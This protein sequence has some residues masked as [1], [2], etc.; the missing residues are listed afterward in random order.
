MKPLT[1]HRKL[2][3]VKGFTPPLPNW[4]ILLKIGEQWL[5]GIKG[6]GQHPGSAAILI[7][8]RWRLMNYIKAEGLLEKYD[9]FI[10]TRS[11]FVWET[12]H[13]PIEY[14]NPENIWVPDGESHGGLTDRHAVVSNKNL[15]CYLDLLK[16]IITNPHTLFS[17][18]VY[19][20]DWNLEQLIDFHLKKSG[21]RENVRF[22]PYVMYSARTLGGNTR[23]A[24]GEWSKDLG[25]Y[26]KYPA[27]F[28]AAGSYKRLIQSPSDWG[29]YFSNDGTLHLNMRIKSTHGDSFVLEHPYILKILLILLRTS[30]LPFHALRAQILKILQPLINKNISSLIT[31]NFSSLTPNRLELSIDY[32]NKFGFLYITNS[33]RGNCEKTLLD[34]VELLFDESG[35]INLISLKDQKFYNIDRAGRLTK[36]RETAHHF[37]FENKYE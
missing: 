34:K 4:R 24:Q 27:E 10:V 35:T 37:T 3:L 16:P 9:T 21:L 20:N 28:Q 19:R 7:Y 8:F 18:M 17:E 26:I 2:S 30:K 32:A 6:I 14:L 25:Y 5:G 29:R 11:D 23:W 36:S 15:F 31:K 13:P 22:F 33:L 12:F 1:K